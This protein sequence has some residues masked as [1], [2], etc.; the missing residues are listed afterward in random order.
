MDKISPVEILKLASNIENK[1]A[2]FYAKVAEKLKDEP[3][4][5]VLI[6]LYKEEVQHKDTYDRM[7]IE[8]S[9]QESISDYF[10]D[11]SAPDELKKLLEGSDFYDKNILNGGV[12]TD[13]SIIELLEF[14]AEEEGKT[15]RF[16]KMLKE[17]TKG[18]TSEVVS[19]ILK[20]EEN[21]LE[22]IERTIESI[23]DNVKKGRPKL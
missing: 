21:H 10:T 15:I 2:R 6:Y 19:K 16:Y 1:G 7:R 23:K 17:A 22:N 20:Q 3:M 12:N 4:K 18:K 13:I 9:E 14:A 5:R 8:L 11:P